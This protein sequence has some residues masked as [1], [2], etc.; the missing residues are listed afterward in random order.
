MSAMRLM[1][2]G[3]HKALSSRSGESDPLV[4]MGYTPPAATTK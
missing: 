4:T 1:A 2:G 3:V